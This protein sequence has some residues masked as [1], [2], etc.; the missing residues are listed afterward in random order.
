MRRIKILFLSAK[1]KNLRG[2][3]SSNKEYREISNKILIG[4]DRNL[5]EIVS[6]WA[7]RPDDLQDLLLK[8]EPDI[9]HLSVPAS[10]SGIV[11][12]DENER[13]TI[14]PKDAL[15]GLLQLLKGGIKV[16]F[17][18]GRCSEQQREALKGLVD[19]TII[20]SRDMPGESAI[21]FARAFYRSLAFGKSVEQAFHLAENDLHLQGLRGRKAPELLIN[22]QVDTD[23]P[24]SKTLTA[25]KTP[26]T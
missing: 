11:L 23:L 14:V 5:F 7:V 25:T 24:F 8:N 26:E 21:R 12:E 22:P 10:E 3:S 17:L 20:L 13:W 1:P 9:L 16:V 15:R 19:Y 18:N 4:P 6:A 2:R